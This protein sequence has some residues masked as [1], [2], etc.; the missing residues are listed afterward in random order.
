MVELTEVEAKRLWTKLFGWKRG[1]RVKV[2]NPLNSFYGSRGVV[3]NFF[4][5]YRRIFDV[6]VTLDG[7]DYYVYFHKRDLERIPNEENN[8]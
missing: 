5:A 3:Q 8:G 2:T 7:K 1:D 4:T 6:G